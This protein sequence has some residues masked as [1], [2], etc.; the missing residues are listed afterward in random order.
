MIG[1]KE[2]QRKHLRAPF[3]ESVLFSDGSYLLRA[4]AINISEGGM[5]LDE[6]PNFP[7]K[8]IV[9]IL[10]SIPQIPILKN[11]T[12]LKMQT[13]SKDIFPTKVIIVKARMIRRVDLSQNLENL[14]K[15]KFGL[16]FIKPT[17]NEQKIIDEYVTTYA[18]N[19][20]YLQ[21][22]IDSY[23]A[24]E[25]TRSKVRSLASILGYLNIERIAELRS[26]VSLDY[27]SLQWL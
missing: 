1:G 4:K 15:A 19:L 23:N 24:D 16:E 26:R 14:F 7:D 5:L 17:Q 20:V 13:F 10:I 6:I 27:R 12:L 18:S 9:P 3:K 2:Y 8:D 21:M 22:L 11:F 25:D